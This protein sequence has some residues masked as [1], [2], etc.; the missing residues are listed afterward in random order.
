[1]QQAYIVY[2]GSFQM[3]TE[4]IH[5]IDEAYG[6]KSGCYLQTR[7]GIIFSV[8]SA[9]RS[10]SYILKPCLEPADRKF[11]TYAVHTHLN[12]NGFSNT[13]RILKTSAGG[14]FIEL[15]GRMYTC[16]RLPQGRQCC[17]ECE[18]DLKNAAALLA[19]MHNASTGFTSARAVKIIDSV[20]PQKD[21]SGYVR[22]ELGGIL[23]LYEHRSR[24]L[25]R[26][27]RLASR[28]RGRFDYEYLS[29]ADYYCGIAE[30]MCKALADSEYAALSQAY[31]ERGAICH[32]DYASHNIV[33]C[34]AAN[35]PCEKASEGGAGGIIN[36]DC[37]AIDLPLLDLTNLMKRRMR[38]CGWRPADAHTILN[39]YCRSRP[40]S[41]GEI[42]IIKIVLNFP[43]KLWR[44]VNKYYNSRRSWCEKSCLMKLSEIKKERAQMNE[45]IKSF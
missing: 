24:E 7:E 21:A 42:E 45:F 19:A 38:K 33:L 30:E 28:S 17:V 22:N 39:S 43:Q 40:L 10:E 26:F 32:R 34:A 31:S 36:F 3:D 8:P 23:P 14:I 25:A 20:L 41:A 1:M 4:N 2:E 35:E 11:F 37:A 44:I 16:S 9:S 5:I 6:F 27:K 13:D 29:I 18:S 12:E 15:C